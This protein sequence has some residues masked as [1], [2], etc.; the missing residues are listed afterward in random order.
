MNLIIRQIVKE[1]NASLA[2][3]I[4]E[5][6]LEHDAPKTG[7]VYSDPRTDNLYELFQAPKSILWVAELDNEIAGCCG[8]Y[9]TDGLNENCTE[10]VKFYLSKGARGKGIGKKLM[11]KSIKTA[12]DL[13]YSQIYL[14]SLPQFANA[15]RIY[16]TQGFVRL[17]KPL[18][19]SGHSTCNIWMLKQL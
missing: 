7:T 8:I 5:V 19:N 4:R 11:L 15:V 18:G 6:F 1:D 12:R 13:K 14:E 3:I 2:R 9:P 16:E 10:L 17:S